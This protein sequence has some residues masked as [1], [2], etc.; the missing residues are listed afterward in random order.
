MTKQMLDTITALPVTALEG[1]KQFENLE[2]YENSLDK[3]K[4]N[5]VPLQNRS[6]SLTLDEKIQNLSSKK[7]KLYEEKEKKYQFHKK[8]KTEDNNI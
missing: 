3:K 5:Y 7:R 6:S 2:E 4:T 1:E 8:R